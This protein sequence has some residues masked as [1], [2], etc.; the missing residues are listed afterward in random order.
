MGSNDDKSELI[1]PLEDL[2]SY[3]MRRAALATMTELGEAYEA[4]G[5]SLTEAIILRFV[6]ANPGCNQAAISRALGVTRTNMVPFVSR[7]VSQGVLRREA[8]DGRTNALYITPEGKS[9][10]GRLSRIA[11][12]H[13]QKFFGDFDEPTKAVL[14]ETFRVVRG[15]ALK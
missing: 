6:G 13:E 14:R 1:D 11:L 15:K 9:L 7:L 8:S 5:V 10:L 3:Q 4:V 2:L 12:K